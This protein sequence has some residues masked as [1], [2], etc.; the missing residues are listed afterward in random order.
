MKSIKYFASAILCAVLVLPSAFAAYSIDT[1]ST[2]NGESFW[3]SEILRLTADLNGTNLT[4][5]VT[6]KDGSLFKSSGTLDFKVGSPETF[7]GTRFETS[8]YDGLSSQEYTHNLD[9]YLGIAWE[10]NPTGYPKEF[11][12]RYEGPDKTWAWVGPIQVFYEAD[13]DVSD[14]APTVPDSGEPWAEIVGIDSTYVIGESVYPFLT[15]GDDGNLSL[16]DF[17]VADANGNELYRKNWD[18]LSGESFQTSAEFSTAGWSAGW[19]RY[20]SYVEDA[21]GHSVI[22]EGD[23]FSLVDDTTSLPPDE[24]TTPP[25]PPQVEEKQICGSVEPVKLSSSQLLEQDGN[26]LMNGTT[27]TVLSEGNATEIKVNHTSET[28]YVATTN[29]S[30]VCTIPTPLERLHE[31]DS[32]EV[33]VSTPVG[34]YAHIA[35]NVGSRSVDVNGDGTGNQADVIPYNTFLEVQRV[36]QNWIKVRFEGTDGQAK[37]G[38]IYRGFVAEGP[39]IPQTSETREEKQTGV[40]AWAHDMTVDIRMYPKTEINEIIWESYE[41]TPVQIIE[42]HNDLP[43]AFVKIDSP[44]KELDEETTK[45]Y[46]RLYDGVVDLNK[47]QIGLSGWVHQDFIK[48]DGQTYDTPFAYPFDYDAAKSAP[49]AEKGLVTQ[50]FFEEVMGQ[51]HE[52]ID[53]NLEEG[54]PVKAA[55][56][57]TVTFAWLL[58]GLGNTVVLSHDNGYFTVYAHLQEISVAKDDVIPMEVQVG[59]VGGTADHD[60]GSKRPHLHFCVRNDGEPQKSKNWQNALNPTKYVAGY[61]ASDAHQCVKD[62]IVDEGIRD[63]SDIILRCVVGIGGISEQDDET[64]ALLIAASA[65]AMMECALLIQ[66][67]DFPVLVINEKQWYSGFCIKAM[68]ETGILSTKRFQVNAPKGSNVR[69]GPFEN[70]PKLELTKGVVELIKDKQTVD[71]LYA[72]KGDKV[73]ENDIWYRVIYDRDNAIYAYV[74]SGAFQDFLNDDTYKKHQKVIDAYWARDKGLDKGNRVFDYE[75]KRGTLITKL[76][77]SYNDY[78]NAEGETDVDV[79]WEIIAAI[80]YRETRSST[81]AQDDQTGGNGVGHFQ[82]DKINLA[83]IERTKTECAKSVEIGAR[84]V[85]EAIQWIK[86][87]KKSSLMGYDDK[88]KEIYGPSV[89]SP[90]FD[91]DGN[92]KT[93]KVTKNLSSAENEDVIKDIFWGYNGRYDQKQDLY[94][95]QGGTPDGSSY[96]MNQFKGRELGPHMQQLDGTDD[97]NYGAYRVFLELEKLGL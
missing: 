80:H 69:T 70:K 73:G 3:E 87:A 58:D 32:G 75:D 42:Q 84:C 74:H 64:I 16:L 43:F 11:Y 35:P 59:T 66:S 25:P 28:G 6:K 88:G 63:I 45:Q 41:C 57:G 90:E 17:V 46:G 39:D 38:W 31:P 36:W 83:Q 67:D 54:T 93:T 95:Y 18:N 14:P 29:L 71:V 62:F 51:I 24:P 34:I 9:D 21:A 72:V 19:Y 92:R 23:G 37:E 96:V 52:C 13:V 56:R 47:L 65:K 40:I 78:L 15:A 60:A 79:P 26:I 33:V 10:N 85:G 22:V 1:S 50:I 12:A 44:C 91:K 49:I 2:T 76:L 86:C 20:S 61:D 68:E 4:L 77:H 89:C 5:T 48:R 81:T 27:V 94:E 30:E 55:A 97:Q 8:V 53:Y 82:F 7:G